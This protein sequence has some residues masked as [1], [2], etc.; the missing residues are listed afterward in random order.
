MKKIVW[1]YRK[2]KMIYAAIILVIGLVIFGIGLKDIVSFDPTTNLDEV[3]VHAVTEERASVTV[4]NVYDYFC[5]YG[6]NE[7]TRLYFVEV[8][9]EGDFGMICVKL[10][11]SQNT[12]AYDNMNKIIAASESGNE[13]DTSSLGLN[14]FK[15]A[16]KI[17]PLAGKERSYYDEYINS[18]V[19]MGY[20]LEDLNNLFVPS[21]IV[22]DEKNW[23]F[24]GIGMLFMLAA[25]VMIIKAF[26]GKPLRYIKNYCLRSVSPKEKY[27]EL[28]RFYDNTE[29]Q[30]HVKANNEIIM[31][32]DDSMPFVI[33]IVDIIWVYYRTERERGSAFVHYF[34][35]LKT[36][37]G[38]TYS[39]PYLEEEI[40]DAMKYFAKIIPDAIFG[41]SDE[42][43]EIYKT[44][45][46]LMTGEVA[47]RRENRTGLKENENIIK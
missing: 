43:L 15:V 37:N 44:N 39:I 16:G 20:A 23:L 42:N 29:T 3:G 40:E 24:P 41:Y 21:V 25:V 11:G 28:K 35:M 4:E 46:E 38:Y 31:T 1:K 14:S 45:R 34:V 5:S 26:L 10:S 13:I 47:K 36:S 7:T 17:S 32:V 33:D 22:P 19:E 6:D 9:K 18:F 8:S 27:E 30:C 12:K 2:E